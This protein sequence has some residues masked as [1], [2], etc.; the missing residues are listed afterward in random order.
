MGYHHW[1]KNMVKS[2]KNNHI[3]RTQ[4]AN[5]NKMLRQARLNYYSENIASFQGDPKNLFKVAKHLLECLNEGVLPIDKMSAD[6]AQAFS[7]FFIKK[8]ETFRP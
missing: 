5:V 6:I 4:C 8:I 7:D 2:G 1:L 3:Y